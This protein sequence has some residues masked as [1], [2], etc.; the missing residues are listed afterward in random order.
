MYQLKR[1]TGMSYPEA[2]AKAKEELHK[3]GFGVL[4]EIDV[5]STLKKKLDVDFDDYMILGACN[6][7]FAYQAL[8]AEQDLGLMLP[9]NLVVYSKKGKTFVAAIKPTVQMEKVG[10]PKLKDIAAQVED[11]L[12]KVIEAI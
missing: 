10:N 5:K 9:C 2:V 12:K 7:P 1:E 8:Q 3:E 11:K 6:P 4:T